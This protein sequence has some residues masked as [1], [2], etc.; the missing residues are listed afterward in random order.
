MGLGL[1]GLCLARGSVLTAEKMAHTAKSIIV[2]MAHI[3]KS[4]IVYPYDMSNRL[5]DCFTEGARAVF[6]SGCQESTT[7]K[8]VCK[9]GLGLMGLCL[10]RG[11]V[12][13]AKKMTHIAKNIIVKMT[14]TLRRTPSRAFGPASD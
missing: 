14:H 6:V 9:M 3:A 4:I 8:G 12:L 10:A 7:S 5:L 13:T 11:P 1:A 2:T